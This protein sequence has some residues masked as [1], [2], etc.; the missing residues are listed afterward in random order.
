MKHLVSLILV[1]T[2][3]W[4]LPQYGA[5]HGERA[6]QATTRMRTINWYDVNITPIRVAVGDDVFI[7]G[8]F[9]PSNF[10]PEHIPSVDG[11]VFLN[12]GTSG[13]NF[14]RVASSID[15]VSMVQS[16]SL[17]LGRDYSFEIK[18]RAR[19]PGRFHV[20][21]VLS[22]LDAGGIVGP[23][24][25]VEVGG[26]ASDFVNEA[27]TMFGRHIDLERFNLPVIFSWHALWFVIGGAWLFYWLRQRPLLVPRM[28]AVDELEAAGR[29]GD[30]LITT[31]DQQVAIGF[32]IVTF[33]VIIAG[34][35]WAEAR[36][37]VTTPLRTAKVTV[38]EKDP[39]SANV[40][41]QLTE[42]QYRIPGRSF[43]MSLT[44]ENRSAEPL[45]VSEFSTAN[46]RFIN[47]AVLSL[48]PADSHDLVARSGL[49]VEGGE[50]APGATESIEVYAED[51]LWETQRLS[52]MINDPDS[53]IAGLL[54]FQSSS[55]KREIV[56][57][58]GNMLPVFN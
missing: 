27:E 39:P 34:Y 17:Q 3:A 29:D 21:P 42:A 45:Q 31:R 22:V 56:E 46:L 38:P 25:W 57:I 43:R 58:G 1:A 20:H 19:R 9:R 49:R 50:I 24:R 16:T 14:V 30:E 52:H 47:P 13:P 8:R 54:F 53:I 33:V 4:M 55:G 11:R 18:M 5:A 44:V 28:R 32:V 23:G 2:I 51:A 48:E 37:P 40:S 41:V 6:Q 12:V 26:A 35:Q 36:H 15:G 7:R 10:W